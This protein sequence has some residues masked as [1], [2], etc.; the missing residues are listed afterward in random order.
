M[1]PCSRTSGIKVPSDMARRPTG[2]LRQLECLW[3]KIEAFELGGGGGTGPK[4][5]K[6]DPGEPGAD[7]QDG[8]NGV[9]GKSAYEVAVDN[10]F[11]GTEPQWVTSLKGEAGLNGSNGSNG[12]D[13][14][15][16]AD[17]ADGASAY[18]LAVAQGFSGTLAQWIASLKG[19]QGEAGTPGQNGTNGVDGQNGLNG[20]D[21]NDGAD[22]LSA[23]Q[24]AVA[25]GFVGT[26]AAWLLSLKGAKGDTGDQ[27]IQGET[28]PAGTGADPWTYIKLAADFTTSSATAVDITGM[29]FTPA[30][31][32][33]Y[34]FEAR[35]RLRTA[36]ATVGAKPG[37][38]WP[39]GFTDGGAEARAPISAT[40]EVMAF[41]NPNAA[42]LAAVTALPNTTQSWPGYVGGEIQMGASPSGTVK[43]Q[44]ASET[45]GTNVTC[46]AG[47][48]LRYREIA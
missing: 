36:T 38:A 15:D 2:L 5:D 12:S 3:D 32:K 33:R 14:Q 35:L 17:G 18:D 37:L 31:N 24:V 45:A 21:G 47:S 10:G 25:N 4:G 26:E 48:W 13:G 23:Y 20:S 11:V 27:G 16:G 43:L 9:N 40:A 42:I 22:G 19:E 34:E 28:G 41:G 44:L 6:G 46:K 29:A 30:A 39:T 1:L 8:T 7:G